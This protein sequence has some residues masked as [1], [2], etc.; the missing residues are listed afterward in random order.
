MPKSLKYKHEFAT[1]YPLA[2][3]SLCELYTFDLLAGVTNIP[4]NRIPWPASR[5]RR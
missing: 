2:A 4:L 3:H 5:F 1:V